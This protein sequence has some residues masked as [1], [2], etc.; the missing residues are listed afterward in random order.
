MLCFRSSE[1]KSWEWFLHMIHDQEKPKQRLMSRILT[2]T[3][4]WKQGTQT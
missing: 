3:S 2:Q 4:L 1:T